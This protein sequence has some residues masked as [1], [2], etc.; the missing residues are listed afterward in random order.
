MKKKPHK[1]I[2]LG[3]Q[4]G[5]S[6]GAFAWGVLDYLLE[7]NRLDI[8]GLSATSAGS[9]NAIVL[10][11]GLLNNDKDEAR[12]K[13]YDFWRAIS[14]SQKLLPLKPML[15]IPSFNTHKFSLENS[16]L[17]NWLELTTHI[18]SPYQFNPFN[19]NP[20]REI[21]EDLID[22]DALNKQTKIK[23]FIC[24]TNVENCKVKIF[25]NP[26]LS[27]DSVL[28]SACLPTLFQAV[29]IDGEYFWDGG[30]IGNP[31]LFPLIYNCNSQ[32]IVIVHINPIVREGIP[33][34]ASEVLNRINEVSFNS[35]LMREMR[36][37][38]FV[39]GLID[40][41]EA[42]GLKL[43]KMHMHSIR[44]DEEMTQHD[45]SSK[46]NADWSFL[47]HLRDRGR[48]YAALW[49]AENYKKIGKESSIDIRKE[50]L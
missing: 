8:E 6:H 7:D 42:E 33:Q 2:N 9:M 50:F 13:L 47:I 29:E 14:D 20:M 35:S 16:P 49:L 48:H 38:A 25:S 17:Y 18:F 30:Y 34:T 1:T 10:A 21:L 39:S 11:Q 19:I 37:V 5:G 12:Q 41:H 27:V 31:A 43:K 32:D 40:S 36:A 3:L 24:A 4:G 23:L 44:S 22:F 45:V 26:D 15:D 28:A 46:L